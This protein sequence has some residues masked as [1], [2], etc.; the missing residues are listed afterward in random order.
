MHFSVLLR[1]H[2]MGCENLLASRSQRRSVMR[3]KDVMTEGVACARPNDS[4]ALAAERMRDLNIGVLPVC[5]NKE[6]LVGMI[7]DRDITVRATAEGCA[8]D[9]AT[10]GDCMTP[11]IVYCFED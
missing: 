10:V 2:G 6:K 7:T 8:P 11:E 5:G 3:V 9:Q 4:I 1:V